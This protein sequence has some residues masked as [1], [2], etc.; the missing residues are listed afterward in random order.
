MIDKR[1][2][3]VNPDGT[4]I[5]HYW[6]DEK[7]EGG[8]YQKA[9]LQPLF[10]LTAQARNNESGNWKGEMHH[11][12]SVHPVVIEQWWSELGS[13]PLAP[14]NRGWLMKRLNDRDYSKFRV[15]SG[16]L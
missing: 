6:D 4:Q 9:D 14:E 12:A 10:D 15:K 7:Q 5:W 3:Y 11:V 13:N 2:L 1:L 16:R 8:F